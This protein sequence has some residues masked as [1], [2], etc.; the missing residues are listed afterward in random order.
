[1]RKLTPLLLTVGVL[2]GSI[3]IAQAGPTVNVGD[4]YFVKRSGVPTVTTTAGQRATFRFVGRTR[5]TV[6]VSSGPSR[7]SS[8]ARSSGTYRSPVLR[9]GTY[10]IFCS[11]HGSSDQ[12]MTLVVR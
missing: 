3:A 7:F 2:G 6:V 11:I 10:R 8:P 12:R 5:H 1:M 9:R 4:N